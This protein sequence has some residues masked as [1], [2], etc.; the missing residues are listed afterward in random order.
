MGA[1]RLSLC[2]K[3]ADLILLSWLFF[4]KVCVV[5]VFW[6]F[7]AHATFFVYHSHRCCTISVSSFI[8]NGMPNISISPKQCNRRARRGTKLPCN[9]IQVVAGIVSKPCHTLTNNQFQVAVRPSRY[10]RTDAASEMASAGYINSLKAAVQHV[11]TLSH[12]HALR[13]LRP[14]IHVPQHATL[15]PFNRA[16]QSS[17]WLDGFTDGL[18]T[19]KLCL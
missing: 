2:S 17:Q 16:A 11:R 14:G 7:S 3:P 10:L 8:P 19:R 12:A 5:C 13:Q 15:L 1:L 6:G 4:A 9:E 18:S